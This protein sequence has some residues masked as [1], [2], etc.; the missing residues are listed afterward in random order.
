MPAQ[1]SHRPVGPQDSTESTAPTATALSLSSSPKNKYRRGK[2][3]DGGP[4]GNGAPAR[5]KDR[6][7]YNRATSRFDG[8][9]R[10]DLRAWGRAF[11]NVPLLGELAQAEEW[12]R[13][14]RPGKYRDWSRFLRNWLRRANRPRQRVPV[15]APPELAGVAALLQAPMRGRLNDGPR[16]VGDL[17]RIGPHEVAAMEE[18]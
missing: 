6:I 1:A 3:K 4:G 10:E 13:D 17:L 11:P 12:L 16:R 9:T 5:P 2:Q 7:R 18:R 8:V 15:P 14:Q